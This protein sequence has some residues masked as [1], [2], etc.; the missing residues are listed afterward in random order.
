MLRPRVAHTV[1]REGSWPPLAQA[2]FPY[3]ARRRGLM[4]PEQ[5]VLG[6][7]AVNNEA[8]QFT[9]GAD[10][11]CSGGHEAVLPEQ[12][13]EV[14]LLFAVPHRG[15]TAGVC[16]YVTQRTPQPLRSIKGR[17]TADRYPHFLGHALHISWQKYV[18]HLAVV[19][20]VSE[21]REM[22]RVALAKVLPRRWEHVQGVAD[23]AE[24]VSASLALSGDV[25]VSA[26]WLHDVGYA[27][28]LL[29]TGFHPLDGAR[30]L[31]G[32]GVPERVVNLVARH[33]NA[34]LEAELRGI[35]DLVAVFPDEG[36]PLRDALWY[37]DLTTSPDGRPVSSADRMSEIK[38]RYGPGTIVTR[39]ITDGAPELLAAVERTERRL[40]GVLAD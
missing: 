1:H 23:K 8:Q 28:E 11:F 27:P 7:S 3:P 40:A 30:Y 15:V 38:E 21:A 31:A 4:P 37:C 32:V 17:R 26:A 2:A 24:R 34:I 25:L 36:G 13:T 12:Q 9:D 35:G 39:F 19:I 33:S 22:A 29:S 5:Q 20:M 16:P 10:V 18:V 14:Q 6:L